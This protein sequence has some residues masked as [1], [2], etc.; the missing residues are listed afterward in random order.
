MM[1]EKLQRILVHVLNITLICAI[2]TACAPQK[3]H[4]Q[5][6]PQNESALKQNNANSS[7]TSNAP[8]DKKTKENTMIKLHANGHVMD[9]ELAHNAAT[10]ELMNRLAQGPLTVRTQDYAGWEKVG[11]L[12][13]N[14]PRSDEHVSMQ[15]GDIMLYQGNQL[16]VMYGYNE[17]SETRIGTIKNLSASQ[18][19]DIFG[20]GDTEFTFTLN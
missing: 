6:T 4:A 5:S 8:G 1:K 14:L 18:L 11:S 12:G 7:N 19:K 10:E 15:P 16:V 20:S 2:L 3:Q 13:F 17:W 9:V